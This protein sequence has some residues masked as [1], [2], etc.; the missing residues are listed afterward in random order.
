VDQEAVATESFRMALDRGVGRT[1]STGNL[2]MSGARDLAVED[3][4]EEFGTAQP[5]GDGER[6]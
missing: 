6:L 1:D 3:G 2:A 4:L 5:I